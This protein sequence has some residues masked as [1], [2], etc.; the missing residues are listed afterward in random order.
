MA[1]SVSVILCAAGASARFGGDKKKPFVELGGRAAFLR[2]IEAFASR[3]DVKQVLLCIAPDDDELV[4]LKWGPT[5]GFYGVKIVHGGKERFETVANALAKVNP[6]AD[7]IAVHDSVRCCVTEEWITQVFQKAAETGAAILACPVNGTLKR[8]QNALIQQTV[9]RTNLW[10]PR[11][12][13]S[14]LRTC[15]KK[16]MPTSPIWMPPKSPTTPCW[17]KASATLL[18]LSKPTTLI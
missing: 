8:V 6:D 1:K 3:D 5:M 18:R 14:S 15:S 16:P 10:K 9:D 7:L 12:R 17:S 2:S 13:R 4:R 11:P